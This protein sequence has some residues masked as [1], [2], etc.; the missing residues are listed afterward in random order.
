MCRFITLLWHTLVFKDL[1]PQLMMTAKVR[2]DEV[3]LRSHNITIQMIYSNNIDADVPPDNQIVILH[4][5]QSE[6]VCICLLRVNINIE[7]R[8]IEGFLV[9]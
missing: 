4:V 5:S 1:L 8:V 2:A 9:L 7:V 6:L 3:L